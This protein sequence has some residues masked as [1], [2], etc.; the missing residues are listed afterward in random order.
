MVFISLYTIATVAIII[1]GTIVSYEDIK[2]N[3]IRNKHLFFGIVFALLLTSMYVFLGAGVLYLKTVFINSLFSLFIGFFLWHIQLWTAGD[4]KLFFTYALLV[5]LTAY[6][7][8]NAGFFPA[9]IILIN[10]F[11]P[12]FI[13][14]LINTLIQ[15]N[16]KEKLR[17]LKFTINPY[18][19]IQTSI[20]LFGFVW[21]ISIPLTLL[22]MPPNYF[23]NIILLFIA[24]DFLKKISENYFKMRLNHL[25]FLLALFRFFLE[26]NIVTT[27][28]YATHFFSIVFSYLIL[29]HFILRLGF[30]GNSKRIKI[31]DLIKGYVPMERLVLKTKSGQKKKYGKEKIFFSDLIGMFNKE[32]SIV[33]DRAAKGLSYE[34]IKEIQKLHAAGELDFDTLCV[35]KTVPFAPFMFIGVLLTLLAHGNIFVYFAILFL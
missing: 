2:K 35:H 11:V 5:P 24:L 7:T 17:A 16:R 4:G 9:Y 25:F 33:F 28:E 19:I 30:Y 34:Q 15:T 20:A 22:D 27:F 12:L 6:A 8:T 26:Y 10:T 23:I 1:F 31:K 13:I 3:R 14:L 18:N 21:L 32:K 29:R